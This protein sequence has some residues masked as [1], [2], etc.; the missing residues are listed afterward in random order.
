MNPY[1]NIPTPQH[2]AQR[3]ID[4]FHCDET[5]W[6][7]LENR[8]KLRRGQLNELTEKEHKQL[9]LIEFTASRTPDDCIGHCTYGQ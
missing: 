2:E 9:D 3:I 1:C 4:R 8:R 5:H 6:R 7:S